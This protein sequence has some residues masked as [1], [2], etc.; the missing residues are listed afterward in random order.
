MP[1]PRG[2]KGSLSIIE[3]FAVGIFIVL[4]CYFHDSGLPRSGLDTNT[5]KR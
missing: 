4:T 2:L 3:W 5:A 1:N